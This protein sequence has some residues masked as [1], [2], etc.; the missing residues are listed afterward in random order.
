M[1][2]VPRIT[3]RILD[4]GL[5]IPAT[6]PDLLHSKIGTCTSGPRLTPILVTDVSTLVSIFGAG[7]LV[8]GAAYHIQLSGSLWVT[9][10]ATS[11]NGTIGA[12]TKIPI[13]ASTGTL[14]V[15]LSTYTLHAT[16]AGGAAINTST[17]FIPLPI[18]GLVQIVLGLGGVATNY[19]IKGRDLAGNVYATDEVVAAPAAGTY[20]TTREYSEIITLSSNV[21]PV[22]TTNIRTASTTPADAYEIV[23]EIMTTGSVAGLSMQFRYSLDN[24]R[25][26][27]DT[28]VVPASGV[29]DVQ[30]YAPGGSPPYLGFKF[31]F[32]DGAGPVFFTRGDKFTLQT[33]APLWSTN[34]LIDAMDAIANDPDK[35]QN[36]SGFHA[37]GPADGTVF[38]AVETQLN[39]YADMKYQY[40]FMYLEAPRQDSTPEATWAAAVVASFNATGR[41]TGVVAMDMNVSSPALRT[42]N[43][44]NFGSVYMAR[45][46]ACPISEL[47]SHVDCLTVYGTKTSLDGVTKLYQGD[48]SV[49][50]LTL[51]NIVTARQYAV[52]TG[53]YITRGIL[54]T[55]ETS[56]FRDV[57]NRRVMNVA[58]TVGYSAALT[59]LQAELLA[60]PATGTLDQQEANNVA[61]VI[62]DAETVVLLGGSRQHISKLDVAVSTANPFL[63]DRT[64]YTKIR[65]VPR[66][67]VDFIEQTYSYAP[68]IA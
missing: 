23:V 13:A 53:F 43:R 16:I 30:S 36:Y 54:K 51:A 5:G 3:Q 6:T 42:V 61:Q 58:A 55:L 41:Y 63:Q 7:P 1:S 10:T 47:P 60:N 56:D 22:G 20:S 65:I 62:R 66:G 28:L 50:T 34:A 18:P 2:A 14:A 11:T 4:G 48:A 9:R 46:M 68:S 35:R 38:A 59:F 19:T 24:E 29:L 25:T 26:W 12:V 21:D 57:T 17:G 37:V 64:L 27:S 33:T 15:A 40:R 49:E 31:T 32:A 8:D 67:A 39:F 44:R 52:R 45:L